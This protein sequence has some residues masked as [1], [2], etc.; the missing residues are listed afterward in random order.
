MVAAIQKCSVQSAVN[1]NDGARHVG[2]PR[3]GEEADHVPDFA[4]CAEASQGNG[5]EVL[6]RG[7][8]GVDLADPRGVD[9]S[10]G[11]RVDRDPLWAELPG[12]CLRPADHTRPHD[13][14]ER[15]VVD[16]LLHGAR[17][18]VH[19]AAVRALAEV[20]EAQPREP[21]RRQKEQLDGFLDERV[22][23]VDTSGPRR[24]A[25]VVHEHVDPAE[26]L[27]R[28]LDEPLQVGRVRDVAAH[29]ERSEA[30]GLAVERLA[31][32]REH[33]DVRSLSGKR[34][35]D[36]EPDPFRCTADDRGAASEAEVHQVVSTPTTSRTAAVDSSS[37]PR[38][39]SVRSSSTICSIPAA[40]SLTGTPM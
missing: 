11:D 1:G 9:P 6:A 40:P 18:D 38:S 5:L 24:S 7:A 29:A 16:R 27:D 3:R 33:R 13:V 32:P 30:V 28:L 22:G 31:A 8:V 23:Q 39:S 17:G 4:R 36:T 15:E 20:G 34:L 14:G 37:Q 2:R 21:D 12:E 26:G 35:G 25:R 10:G 19:D